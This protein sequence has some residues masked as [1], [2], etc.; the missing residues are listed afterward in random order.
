MSDLNRPNV[1]Q[2]HLT[3]NSH[4]A[5]HQAS[6]IV[7]NN[8][9]FN[10]YQNASI[11]Q[12]SEIREWLGAPDTSHNYI[13]AQKKKQEGTGEWIFIHPT[14]N[15]WKAH[16]KP[17][18]IQGKG[19]PMGFYPRD[20]L[21]YFQLD[22]AKVFCQSEPADINFFRAVIVKDLQP[23]VCYFYF[24][25]RDNTQ[26]KSSYRGLLLSL[27][28]QMALDE[29]SGIY[30]S[31][32]WLYKKCKAGILQPD[33]Q[34]LESTL[35]AILQSLRLEPFIV[36]DAM[37]EC[38]EVDCTMELLLKIAKHCCVVV[39]S[40]L[41]PQKV[42]QWLYIK[43]E[44]N[45][46]N[47]DIDFYI[48]EHLNKMGLK[49]K[50]RE[51]VHQALTK[52]SQ[53][54]FRWVD[55]QL[56]SLQALQTARA[57]REAL[58]E[59]PKDLNDTYSKS[60]SNI[61][62]KHYQEAHYIFLWLLYAFKPITL[63]EVGEI[64]VIDLDGETFDPEDRMEVGKEGL[65]KIVD[66]TLIV[67]D[68]IKNQHVVQFAHVSVREFLLFDHAKAEA[69]HLFDL[70]DQL[71]HVILSQTCLVYLLQFDLWDDSDISSKCG[72]FPLALYAAEYW[73][74]HYSE[75]VNVVDN[76]LFDL[77]KAMM[78]DQSPQYLNWQ[79]LYCMDNPIGTQLQREHNITVADRSI[80]TALYYTAFLGWT[81]LME[82]IAGM[83]ERESA[84]TMA[85]SHNI[86]TKDNLIDAKNI[87]SGEYGNALQVAAKSGNM[88]MVVSLLQ[89]GVDINIQGGY[90]HTALQAAAHKGQMEIVS[91]LL[92][93][94]ADINVQG[95][96]YGTALGA[97][98]RGGHNYIAKLL[99]QKRPSRSGEGSTAAGA[100][101][102]I[103]GGFYG[104]A[105]QAA[106][107]KGFMEVA[108][109][110]LQAGA[111]IDIQGGE[112]GTALQGAAQGGHLD[113]L[114]YLL[115]EWHANVNLQAG[116][117]STALQAA[118]FRGRKEIVDYLL[119]AEAKVNLEGESMVLLY[120]LLLSM[121]AEKL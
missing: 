64:L 109:E 1:V 72:D 106:V 82:E 37:D 104:T 31:L 57:I 16:T 81:K 60:L 74:K 85:E 62:S 22:Q 34:D 48:K 86:V 36:I 13:D 40:R 91:Y 32:Q 56:R 17:L 75:I 3:I 26:M 107:C 53:G 88:Q 113:I 30:L 119:H 55:C 38:D 90:Y 12:N 71:G 21:S 120:R 51:E 25:R 118:A 10:H 97:A 8:P 28:I 110:L 89:A 41:D 73:P 52:G 29:P 54:Q 39:T 103:Q 6:N 23:N 49:A 76:K 45:A 115:L 98:M 67:V 114:K 68:S 46:V 43:L 77:C 116:E 63:E 27:L 95:G 66:S 111:D 61:N 44:S 108:K 15:E 80:P 94:H 121:A 4:S 59:L 42:T 19:M 33:I 69:K 35:M 112:Y 11:Y 14:Y 105:L 78:N 92:Q 70:N 5:F 18:W 2:E 9:N 65:H 100:D 102:N 24:D 58:N 101:V 93:K 96:E 99:L 79:R 117:Y 47:R 50:L 83:Q 84:D 7:L 87:V 20:L